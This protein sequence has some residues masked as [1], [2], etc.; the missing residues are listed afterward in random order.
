MVIANYLHPAVARLSVTV[1]QSL[2]ID[3]EMAKRRW[4]DIYRREGALD[5]IVVPQ[6]NSAAFPRVRRR[7]FGQQL[8]YHIRG[9]RKAHPAAAS[10]RRARVAKTART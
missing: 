2:R 5:L 10:N 9:K 6:Q 8:G 1:D 3:L 7:R 4:M